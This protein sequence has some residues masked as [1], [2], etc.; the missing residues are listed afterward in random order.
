MPLLAHAETYQVKMLN[1]NETG[2]MAFEPDYL[3]I[4][5]GD[6]VHFIA[7][8]PTHN[9]MTIPNL[10][11]EGAKTVRTPMNQDADVTFQQAGFY[12][13]KCL[14]HFMLGMVMLIE[15]GE[16][17]T[18]AH[19]PDGLPARAKKRFEEIKQRAGL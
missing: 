16:N 10:W 12:G 17:N 5:P 11:P 8:D 2:V 3:H 7:S 13:I 1:S 18:A 6:T 19:I 15:V 9:A 4:Q 14:P